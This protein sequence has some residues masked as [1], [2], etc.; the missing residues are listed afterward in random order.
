MVAHMKPKHIIDLLD[1]IRS[2]LNEIEGEI[3]TED[4]GDR[5]VCGDCG[6]NEEPCDCWGVSG[7]GNR[8]N[9]ET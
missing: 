2:R 9:M 3:G 8:P 4:G 7:P 6:S 5:T 1:E